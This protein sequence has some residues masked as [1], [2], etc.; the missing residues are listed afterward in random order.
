MKYFYMMP[1]VIKNGFWA[2][3]DNGIYCGTSG[4]IGTPGN[5]NKVAAIK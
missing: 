3:F 1:M 5:N 2:L 4:A